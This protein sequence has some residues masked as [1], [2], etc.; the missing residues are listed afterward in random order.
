MKLAYSLLLPL[1]GVSASVINY[2]RDGDS[3]AITNTTFSLNRPSV[4]FT[5]S[6]GWMNDPNGLWYDAKEE[7]WHLYYQ[8]NPAATIWGTPLYWGHAVSKDLTSWTDYGASLGPGSDDA[9]AFSGSMVIDYN[10]TSGFFN[11]SVDPRQRAVA[12]WT[13][14]KGPSQAQHISYSLDGGYTFQHY[15][16]NAVLDINSSNFRDPKVFWHEGENGE[17]GRWIMAVAESQVFS[18]LFYSSPNLKNW[19][20]ESNFTHHGWTGTQYECP[21][22]V[23]VP[24]DSVADSSSN[25]S[26]SKPD[27][28]W[29]LFVSINPGGP[30]GGSVTQYFVGDFNGTH[31]TPIDDQTRFLDMGK[32]YYALQT[33]FNTPNEKDVYGIA[34]ASN[35]QY[36]QQ[37][38]TDPWRSSMSLVRQFTLKDFSTNPNSADVVLN[39]QPVLNY[40]ALRKNGTT[41]S[42]TNYTVTSENGKKIKLDNPS[43][44]LE[45]HLEYVFNGSPDIKSN[46]FAD[47]SL[48][49]KGN[50]DDNE[51]LRL[52]Y[53]TNGGAFFLDRGHTK[54]P[55]VKEN[56]FFNHQLAVT[57]PVSNY[58]T[59]VFDV[60]GVIDKNIIELYFDNGNV[61]STNTFFFS[62]NNV[63][64][65]IDI[66]SPYDK[67]YTINSF[68]VT[69]FNL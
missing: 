41:Y 58:T 39:S 66:K 54:I 49:F 12:V 35:W 14:S 38:P 24:Y 57:N 45:F 9:G 65:E 3:K 5:P 21:G 40:D 63:I 2:K 53:E 8:Y 1:A 29:V 47:L 61:V 55:F 10:N 18:V 34:W 69:Q 48:Y 37:A 7:D 17:D 56:L 33:F 52:G 20:L 22:L 25:S 44:S 67:A 28:A 27:S 16:D 50:N 59:N 42:I 32:D 51:Y 36:A 13:L 68:N 62:T 60:Y 11:S 43:G 4:H 26:D 19:T 30:L 46:V 15:S 31:F 23:K 6:H 64:G